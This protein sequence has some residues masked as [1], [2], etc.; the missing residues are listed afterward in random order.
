MDSL[1][2]IESE[3][4]KL[5]I[6]I[7]TPTPTETLKEVIQHYTNTLCT[8]QKQTNLTTSSLQDIPVVHEHDATWLEDWLKDIEMAADLTNESKANL[9]KAKSRGLTHT[10]IMEA[11]TLDKLWEDIKNFSRVKLCNTDIHIYISHFMEIQQWENE[12][13]AEYIHHF[14]TEARR[15]NFTNNAATI[16]IFIKGLK[17]PMA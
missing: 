17:M 3:L 11:I 10:L 9:A 4:Q 2:H 13:L 12:S 6:T 7:Y 8:A 5:T 1:D 15:C 14:K 16:R